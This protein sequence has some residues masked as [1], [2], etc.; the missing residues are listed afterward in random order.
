LTL[1]KTSFH[2]PY[3]PLVIPQKCLKNR[4]KKFW[5]EKGQGEDEEKT[6]TRTRRGGEWG[7]EWG[8]E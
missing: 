4:G 8:G 5:K 7:G 2:P 6:R 1:Y 3:D